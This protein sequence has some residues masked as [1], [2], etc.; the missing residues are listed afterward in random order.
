[1]KTTIDREECTLCGLCWETCPDFFEENPEDGM[2]QI[3]ED[4]RADRKISEGDVPGSLEECVREAA[5]DCPVEIIHV[6]E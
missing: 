1:M 2:V 4:Y 5:G 6:Q 3:I